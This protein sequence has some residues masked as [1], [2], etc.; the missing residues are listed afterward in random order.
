MATQPDSR[1][2][3]AWACPVFLPTGSAP[4]KRRTHD[5]ARVLL[6]TGVTGCPG[7]FSG[8]SVRNP[9]DRRGSLRGRHQ[10]HLQC[11]GRTLRHR[12]RIVTVVTCVYR[13]HKTGRRSPQMEE[14]RPTR[15]FLPIPFS[16]TLSVT[17]RVIRRSPVLLPEVHTS[18]PA[19]DSSPRRSA[20]HYRTLPR[21]T[22]PVWPQSGPLPLHVGWAA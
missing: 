16:V 19:P 21:P 11:T 3:G 22:L 8:E 17:N 12:Y 15:F 4:E 13:N 6:G 5:R 20:R 2:V 1:Q 9:T 18:S 10:A 14:R 7:L